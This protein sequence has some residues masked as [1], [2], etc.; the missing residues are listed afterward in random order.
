MHVTGLTHAVDRLVVSHAAGLIEL[1][2]CFL[3]IHRRRR[4]IA[5][6][7]RDPAR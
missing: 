1:T 3:F 4:R 5:R 6:A 7:Q 2:S